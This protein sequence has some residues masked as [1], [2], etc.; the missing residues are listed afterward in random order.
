MR[1]LGGTAYHTYLVTNLK[2]NTKE[3]VYIDG[4]GRIGGFKFGDTTM[5]FSKYGEAVSIVAPM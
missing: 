3:T 2:K 1:S 5:T 4:S